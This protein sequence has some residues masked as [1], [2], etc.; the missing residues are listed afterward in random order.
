LVARLVRPQ[1]SYLDARIDDVEHALHAANVGTRQLLD[2]RSFSM[3]HL[4]AREVHDALDAR[5][6]LAEESAR[7][8]EARQHEYGGTD[9]RIALLS[10]EVA[11]LRRQIQRLEQGTVAGAPGPAQPT[12]AAPQPTAD[13]GVDEQLYLAI[14]DRFRGDPALIRERH[15][16]YVPFLADVADTDHPVLDLGC[17]RGELLTVL[18]EHGV[19]AHG[20]DANRTVVEECR[21]AGLDV[22]AGDLVEVLASMPD[23]AVGAV[24][25]FHVVE[26]LPLGVLADVLTECARVLRPGGLLVAET[27]N[28][29]NFR[30]AATTFW[31]DPTHV[32]PLHPELLRLLAERAGFARMEDLF[33]H[34]IGTRPDLSDRDDPLGRWVMDLSWSTDGPGDYGLL[35]WTPE[36]VPAGV[37]GSAG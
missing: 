27:P 3:A 24:T 25:M 9:Q 28:A 26:H 34:E 36:M 19:P 1:V 12:A 15:E 13:G 30:V 37:E 29:L 21:E 2:E 23:G 35:A 11:R 6:T 18:R 7:R 31:I 5:I 32:R 10:S 8:S 4:A 20:V 22:S 14:E 16:Q 17:G 33:L